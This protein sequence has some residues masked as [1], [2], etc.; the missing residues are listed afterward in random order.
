MAFILTWILILI[1]TLTLTLL[2]LCH[3]I[4]INFECFIQLDIALHYGVYFDL[5]ID[6]E[7]DLDLDHGLELKVYLLFKNHLV[8]GI[9]HN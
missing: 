7:H 4:N 5:Q 6:L 8:L 1:L 9:E 2:D 3:H